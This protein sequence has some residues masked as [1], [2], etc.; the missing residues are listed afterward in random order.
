MW[1]EHFENAMGDM[2]IHERVH[3]LVDLLKSYG[4]EV[5][6]STLSP[7]VIGKFKALFHT[8]LDAVAQ[9]KGCEE[10]RK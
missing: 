1:K 4:N 3:S 9:G 10:Y 6:I 7:E 2:S 5:G 8:H